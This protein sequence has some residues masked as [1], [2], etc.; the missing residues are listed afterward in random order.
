MMAEKQYA[1]RDVEDP[2]HVI[3]LVKI[4]VDCVTLEHYHHNQQ[5]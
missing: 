2:D 5:N 1:D 4:Y 3:A